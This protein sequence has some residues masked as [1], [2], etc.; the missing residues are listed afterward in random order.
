MQFC[1]VWLGKNG[2]DLAAPQ[3]DTRK[4]DGG[5]KR[6]D[7]GKGYRGGRAEGSE[8]RKI[9]ARNNYMETKMGII[10]N[11]ARILLCGGP[12]AFHGANHS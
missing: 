1:D 11:S 2:V 8:K 6:N 10:V 3:E 9:E 12:S 4:K 7:D 5:G